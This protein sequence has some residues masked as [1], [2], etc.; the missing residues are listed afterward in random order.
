MGVTT[1]ESAADRIAR[2]ALAAKAQAALDRGPLLIYAGAGA[3]K[4]S[5]LAEVAAADSAVGW[6]SCAPGDRE[7]AALLGRI[8][9]ALAGAA[10]EI[11][12]AFGERLATAPPGQL[13]ARAAIRQLLDEIRD[14]SPVRPLLVID[15]AESLDGAAPALELVDELIR[16]E[17]SGTRVALA[18][19]RPL[20]LTVGK[21]VAAGRLTE[22]GP[23]DLA[24]APDECAAVLRAA[25]RADPSEDE[26]EAAMEATE[27]WPLGVS[28]VAR[29][30][31]SP[32][33]GGERLVTY[34][35]E[36]LLASVEPTVRE[37]AVDAAV[38]RE[39]GPKLLEALDLD[40]GF[41]G[42]IQRA[43]LTMVTPAGECVRY[44]PLIHEALRS[45]LVRE[46]GPAELRE[47]H[48]RAA[49]AEPDPAEAIEHWLAA[50]SWRAAADAVLADPGLI[51]VSPERVRG[52]IDRLPAEL[53]EEPGILVARAQLARADGE[54]GTVVELLTRAV[55][56]F[57]DDAGFA[58]WMARFELTMAMFLNAEFEA[59]M[60]YVDGFEAAAE[61]GPV[62]PAT[63]QSVAIALAG[64]GRMEESDALA[65]RANAHPAA[66]LIAPLEAL[67]RCHTDVPAGRL[68]ALPALIEAAF[69]AAENADPMVLRPYL[70]AGWAMVEDD[71]GNTERAV[72]LWG[73]SAEEAAGGL[74][75]FV[76][77]TARCWRSVL[78]AE[79]GRLADAERELSLAGRGETGWR[80]YTIDAARAAVAAQRGDVREAIDAA[81]QA[82]ATVSTGAVQHRVNAIDQL[83]RSLGEIGREDRGEELI[84]EGLG[85]GETMLAGPK[86][87]FFRSRHLALR[88]WLRHRRGESASGD[89][90]ESAAEAGAAWSYVLRKDWSRLE[91]VVWAALEDGSLEPAPTVEAIAAA[92]PGGEALGALSGHPVA[93][94]RAAAI[95]PALAS[96]DPRVLARLGELAED[97]DKRVAARA[98]LALA[99]PEAVA[100]ALRIHLLGT[101]AVSRGTWTARDA[102]WGRPVA[103]RLVRFLAVQGRGVPEDLIFE[104]LWPDL[105]P[106]GARRSLR[107]A[108]SLARKVLAPPGVEHAGVSVSGGS[109]GLE[110]GAGDSVDADRFERAASTAL[111]ASGVE[112]EE[113]LRVARSLWGGEPLPEDRYEDWAVSWRAR[114]VDRY[115]AVL[116]ALASRLEEVGDHQGQLAA[117]RELVEVD[118]LDEGAHRHLMVAQAR[119]GRRG[120]AL[121]QFL[122][123]RR[124]LVAE[125]GLEPSRKTAEL[126]RAILAGE[127]VRTD[128]R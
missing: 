96:G 114:L 46:R 84:A 50:G 89:I 19:R 42:A 13:D 11:V 118:P 115:V 22:L 128:R 110:L 102:D 70:L 103:A 48:A 91:P 47:L 60:P 26:V 94:V 77:Q 1:G 39:L 10:P 120:Q 32:E 64:V 111:A 43:G 58:P 74:A 20:G 4:T 119:I 117:A 113:L 29:T 73:R 41:L 57:G 75:A 78:L 127:E 40:G 3:G 83:V 23:G 31:R 100:P 82:H 121:R 62:A 71:M 87:A 81:E 126:H 79:S 37:G 95:G 8:V 112:R 21:L 45:L 97:P 17:A 90:A 86:G 36:E 12:A 38:A 61:A 55:A 44:H 109:Y 116:S 59:V 24:F 56:A 80:G 53:V 49:D 123:C 27:G 92:V 124:T 18:S 68:E 6:L 5:L 125:L 14:L 122:A 66:A 99:R 7:P 76:S 107:V 69:D 93:A 108:A 35:E 104:A 72:E 28:L 101:F 9:R 34:V 30:G 63:A 25:K 33:H 106:E 16:S 98:A 85:I 15:D 54:H 52:W 65:A 2:P 105:Q 51:A 67:R 88:A